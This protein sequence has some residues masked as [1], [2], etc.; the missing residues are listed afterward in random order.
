MTSASL[1]CLLQECL[2]INFRLNSDTTKSLIDK[3]VSLIEKAQR[4]YKSGVNYVRIDGE[5]YEIG[6]RLLKLL[7]DSAKILC[8]Q[9]L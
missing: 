5:K 1:Y 3:S 2:I 6:S 9:R 8:L 4:A 7:Q